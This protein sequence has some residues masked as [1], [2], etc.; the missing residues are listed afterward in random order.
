GGVLQQTPGRLIDEVMNDLVNN[1]GEVATKAL[2]S[3][4]VGYQG[5]RLMSK[6]PKVG[7][8]VAL[9][10]GA[11]QLG[12]YGLETAGF[13]GEAR[14]ADTAIERGQLIERGSKAVAHEGAL[15]VETMPG[16][17]VGGKL[18][19]NKYGAPPLR[20][21][22][23]ETRQTA[24][25]LYAFRGPGSS[26]V[27]ASVINKDGTVD[28]LQ[29][30]QGFARNNAWTG[31]E[32]GQ[33]VNLLNLRA[34]RTVR[35]GAEKLELGFAD[36]PGRVLLHTHAPTPK[37]GLH[38]SLQDRIATQ[39]VGVIQSGQSTIVYMGQAARYRQAIAAGQ[40]AGQVKLPL[41]ELHLN[42]AT[43]TATLFESVQGGAADA[44]VSLI[45]KQPV[46]FTSAQQMLKRL[47]VTKAWPQLKDLALMDI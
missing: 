9:G 16:L 38:S 5:L 20:T 34:S 8:V 17:L 22:L 30:S 24:F 19:L 31:V 14:H 39:G 45:S 43:R 36:K 25:E 40:K 33:S 2:V 10:L 37:V 18:A 42:A 35:G 46:N 11:W 26:R 15:L 29:L 32:T 27:P 7:G 1:P 12:R 41:Q 21:A 44:T 6:A 3:G 47:D 23:A 13:I 4:I 28:L